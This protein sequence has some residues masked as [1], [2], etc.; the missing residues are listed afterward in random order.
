MFRPSPA[1][2]P[3]LIVPLHVALKQLG[4]LGKRG[5]LEG[6]KARAGVVCAHQDGAADPWKGEPFRDPGFRVHVARDHH[7]ELA[8]PDS[9]MP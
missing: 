7:P 1:I 3:R 4:V 9:S 8:V 6:R 2:Q 5:E